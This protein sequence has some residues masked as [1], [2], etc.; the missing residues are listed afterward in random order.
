ME[1]SAG[2][3]RGAAPHP[4][5]LTAMVKSE[6]SDPLVSAIVHGLLWAAD[7]KKL[8]KW[9]A[10]GQ[11]DVTLLIELLARD[12]SVPAARPD[13][14][15]HYSHLPA[16]SPRLLPAAAGR[17]A[18]QEQGFLARALQKYHPDQD[19]YQLDVLYKLLKFAYPQPAATPGQD[20]SRA[21]IQQILSGPAP[22]THATAAGRRLAVA[23]PTGVP[24]AGLDRLCPRLAHQA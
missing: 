21:A 18:L 19:Q 6:P 8:N 12:N 9:L 10:S 17:A 22:A 15:R 11:V 24:G 1:E 23:A 20:L 4:Q 3:A 2:V 13:R 16:Q 14:L 7:E 5:L